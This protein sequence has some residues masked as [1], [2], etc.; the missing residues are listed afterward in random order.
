MRLKVDDG[1]IVFPVTAKG[2]KVSAEGVFEAVGSGA[3][4][5]EAA[6]EHAKHDAKASQTV[7]AEGHRRRHSVRRNRAGSKA[8]Y[9]RPSDEALGARERDQ[10]VAAGHV[11]L[12]IDVVEVDLQRPLTHRQPVGDFARCAHLRRSVCSTCISRPVSNPE[13]SRRAVSRVRSASIARPTSDWSRHVPPLEHRPH[14]ALDVVDRRVL[15]N[16][17]ADAKLQS[18]EHLR[19]AQATAHHHEG[20]L[21]TASAGPRA[22]P[23]NRQDRPT[24]CRRSPDPAALARIAVKSSAPVVQRSTAA[25]GNERSTCANPSS[26]SGCSSAMTT[27]AASGALLNS[28]P[29]AGS[30]RTAAFA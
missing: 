1:V 5:K 4:S 3:E 29:R 26:M 9:G 14:A 17:P 21:Q 30:H 12:L 27:R 22:A 2:R 20:N 15:R 16:E 18:L 19:I 23:S 6:R 8:R 28:E 7:S 25:V 11:Q 24:E 13:S 10:A